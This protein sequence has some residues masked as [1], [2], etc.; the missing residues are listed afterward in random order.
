MMSFR[1]SKNCLKLGRNRMPGATVVETRIPS[2]CGWTVLTGGLPTE[3]EWLAAAIIDERVLHKDQA[4]RLRSELSKEPAAIVKHSDEMTG[5]VVDGRRVIVRSGPYLV[6]SK[7][8]ARRPH[9][10]SGRSFT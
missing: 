5:T 8:D 9:H 6:R 1:V 7:D 4:Y 2:Q 10:R 3:A